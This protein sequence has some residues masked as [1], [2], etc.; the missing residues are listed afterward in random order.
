[1]TL[2]CVGLCAGSQS[3]LGLLEFIDPY[4]L[5][6][7]ADSQG[8]LLFW[9]VRPHPRS[10][11]CVHA[12]AH[13]TDVQTGHSKTFMTSDIDCRA[14][15]KSIV[16]A[17]KSIRDK[18]TQHTW[19]YTGDEFGDIRCWDLTAM[20]TRLRLQVRSCRPFS[21]LIRSSKSSWRSP[22][23]TD[24]SHGNNLGITRTIC[25]VKRPS[26]ITRIAR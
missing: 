18:R 6:A 8:N 15:N 5:L 25:V 17:M 9:A 2:N 21:I 16:T 10:G 26:R 19:L 12:V 11:E 22:F 4:P 1:M 14:E 7:A 3:E 24:R 20:L 13:I 23:R